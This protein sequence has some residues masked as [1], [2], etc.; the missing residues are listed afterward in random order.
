MAMLRDLFKGR[1]L[2]QLS[3]SW[4][5]M[6]NKLWYFEFGTSETFAATC[7]KLHDHIE[8]E[9]SPEMGVRLP[10]TLVLLLD[11]RTHTV[12]TY[13]LGPEEVTQNGVR[14]SYLHSVPKHLCSLTRTGLITGPAFLGLSRESLQLWCLEVHSFPQLHPHRGLAIAP[15]QRGEHSVVAGTGRQTAGGERQCPKADKSLGADSHRA[16]TPQLTPPPLSQLLQRADSEV[17]QVSFVGVQPVQLLRRALRSM[18]FCHHL[19]ILED[20]LTKSPAFSC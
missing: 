8:L 1:I 2:S 6:K 16:D 9:V 15:L 3:A 13:P 4:R 18:L 5:R 17:P 14:L 10:W 7:K 20:F 11:C 12:R 19:E